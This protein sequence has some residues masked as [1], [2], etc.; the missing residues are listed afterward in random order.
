M[1]RSEL[2]GSIITEENR[3]YF[4]QNTLWTAGHHSIYRQSAGHT[5]QHN[6]LVDSVAKVQD[7]TTYTEAFKHTSVFCSAV[8]NSGKL[9]A[10]RKEN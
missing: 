2:K 10:C 3:K 4:Q 7:P 1:M 6:A 9:V 5:L 8:E